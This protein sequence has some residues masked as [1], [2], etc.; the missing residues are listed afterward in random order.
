MIVIG[1]IND[2]KMA[3]EIIKELEARDIT[4]EYVFNKDLNSH[5]LALMNDNPDHLAAAHELYRVK[6]GLRKPMEVDPEWVKIKSIPRGEITFAILIFCIGLYLL[7]YFP[8]G[9]AIYNFFMMDESKIIKGEIWRLLTPALLHMSILHILFNMLWFKDLGYLLEFAFG[10]GFF[11]KFIVITA[12]F[13]NVLQFVTHGPSFGGMS[14]VLYGMLGFVW[15]YKILNK[16]FEFTIPK[17]DMYLMIFWFFLCLSGVLSMIAN[18]AHAGGLVSGMLVAIFSNFKL[19]KARIK[20]FFL[21]MFFLLITF[22]VEAYKM[23]GKF[24][25]SKWVPI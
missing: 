25:F 9:K 6:L 19:E 5:I 4:V 16:D 24:Y 10:R 21:A 2:P 22:M 17:S 12:L 18:M 11:V 8:Q 14:G 23:G 3:L 15:I 7:S 1:E 20:Y 13:S